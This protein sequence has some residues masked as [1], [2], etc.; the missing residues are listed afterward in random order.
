MGHLNEE[1]LVLHFYGELD[2][3]AAKDADT[4]LTACGDCRA[5]YVR[6]QRVMAAVDTMPEPALPDGFERVT[7]ARLEPSLR[8]R[9]GWRSWLVLSPANVA[10]A[11]AVLVLVAGAFFAG[12]MTREP[13][14]SGRAVVSAEQ[15]RERVLLTDLGEHLDRSQ[16][17]LVDLVSADAEGSVDMSAERRQA[18][19]LVAANRLYRQTAEE[20][21]EARVTELLDEL[22]RLLVDLAASP[23]KLSA[24]DM[25]EVRNRIDANGLLFKVRVLSTAV[26]ERQKQQ[27]RL[28]TTEA[29]QKKTI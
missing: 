28:R 24:A 1:D 2:A 16:M 3:G 26:R 15:V 14:D 9:S 5:G 22:E 11:S 21:G 7:W 10:L 23:D 13:A 20:S 19:E 25:E 8:R 17:M 4:H 12:R 6:L 27:M 29:T 18:E